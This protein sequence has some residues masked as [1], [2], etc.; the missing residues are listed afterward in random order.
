MNKK[1]DE[2]GVM[3]NG[4]ISSWRMLVV[5]N[6]SGRYWD[7]CFSLIYINDLDLCSVENNFNVC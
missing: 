3:V 2:Q 6:P 7:P 5:E 1:K 4:Y